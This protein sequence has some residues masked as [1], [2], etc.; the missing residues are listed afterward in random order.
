M[1]SIH[2]DKS[3]TGVN[4]Y[5]VITSLGI[6]S[7]KLNHLYTLCMMHGYQDGALKWVLRS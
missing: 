2:I 1:C 6:F 5:T 3:A 4:Y 7:K